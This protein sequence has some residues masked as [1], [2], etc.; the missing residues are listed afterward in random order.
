MLFLSNNNK[1]WICEFLSTGP[2]SLSRTSV[3]AL[4]PWMK[5]VLVG[6]AYNIRITQQLDSHPCVI[7][8]EEMAAARHFVRT[9]SHQLPEDSRF[10]LLQPQLEVNPRHPIIKKLA[11]LKDSN[12]RLAELLVKQ[13]NICL[14]CSPY[15]IYCC[16]Q[17]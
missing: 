8:V 12:P 2:D 6:K 11:T 4:L 1:K 16:H 15:F 9:Q 3:D 5:Q 13:V 14:Y 10:S 17:V 7:T